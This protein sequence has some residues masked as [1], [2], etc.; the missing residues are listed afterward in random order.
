M[1]LPGLLKQ[2]LLPAAALAV[3]LGG[4]GSIRRE[5]PVMLY[6]A[7]SV[8]DET[9][10]S[11]EN[12][13]LLRQRFNQLVQDFRRVHPNVL[14]QVALYREGN[15]RKQL[16]VRNQAGLG[17][18]LILTGADSALTLLRA[19]LVDAIPDS[20]ELRGDS[21]P[22]L[23][24]RVRSRD[25]RLAGQPMVLFPQ[26]A[27]YDRRQ[28]RQPPT[29]LTGLLQTSAA[30]LPV[31]LPMAVRQLL[32]TA[33]GFGAV[34]GLAAAEQGHQPSPLERSRIR[35]WLTWLQQASNQQRV[36]FM[37]NQTD[38]RHGLSQGTLAWVSCNSGEL[39]L[40]RH[41]M[42]PHLGVTPLPNGSHHPA[43]PVNRLRVLALG[44][45]SSAIQRQ[46]S[47]KLIRFGVGPLVQRSL[48][49][50]SL[51]FLPANPHVSV[52]V[53]SS[54]VLA[55]MVTSRQQAQN[56][57]H[58]LA[59]IHQ[60]DSRLPKLQSDVIVPVL[61]GLVEPERATDR[62]IGILRKQP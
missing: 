7:I 60:E 50:D 16:Q 32:W 52:P 17:P 30:G 55:A 12:A 51:T 23:L 39:A 11:T 24:K 35:N 34:P 5:L 38:L 62:L 18:D 40:L 49:L 22:E 44:R 56:V 41:R 1:G 8:Q 57:D 48:T 37:P 31:G 46:M 14:V 45:N 20:P 26:L 10:L 33:G 36:L 2:G 53:Q 15:L 59:D 43:S 3:L 61:F 25:G 9:D 28:L 27:C 19:G 13:A 58:L 6:V 42:G 21:D 54:S 4:C 47:L 29:S